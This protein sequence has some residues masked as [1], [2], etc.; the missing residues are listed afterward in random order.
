MEC[1]VSTEQGRT[2]QEYQ[3]GT[4]SRIALPCPDCK[5]WVTPEREHLVGWQ[6]AENQAAAR[7]NGEFGCPA[8]GIVWSV[9]QL[10]EA[11]QRG[12]LLHG[13]QAIDEDGRL[14]GDPPP[15]DTL[16]FRWSAVN[17]LFLLPE[18]LAA[19]EWRASRSAD[20]D[21]AEREMRQFV[22][23][24]PAALSEWQDTPLDEHQLAARMINLP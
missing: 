20:E 3:Q 19:D 6:G 23:C 7:G 17:S 15:T 21:N 12:R 18:D 5:A 24:L 14:V 11:N 4:R 13:D 2:W 22:W 8:C 10:R 9:E 16:G 1:T